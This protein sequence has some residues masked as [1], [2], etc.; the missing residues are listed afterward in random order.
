MKLAD[1]IALLTTTL[2][3][4]GGIP[5]GMSAGEAAAGLLRDMAQRLAISSSIE[6]DTPTTCA[7]C[8]HMTRVKVGDL[9]RNEEAIR[10]G[11]SKRGYPRP[12]GATCPLQEAG[13]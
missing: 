5:E 4:F 8:C 3:E 2:D 13:S 10:A 12:H 11:Y 9:C 6:V 7:H 1:Q